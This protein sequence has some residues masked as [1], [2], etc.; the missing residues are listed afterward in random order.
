VIVR[1]LEEI[2]SILFRFFVFPFVRIYYELTTKSVMKQGT[3]TNKGTRL[4]GKNYIG[5]G[6]VLSNVEFGFGSYVSRDS[7]LSNAKVGKYC[8]IGPNMSCL[9]GSHPTKGFVSTHPAF[10]AATSPCGFS[11]S[12]EDIFDENKFTD[13]SKGYFYEIGNDVWIGANVSLGQGVHIG[14]GAIIGANALVLKDVEPYAI[15]AGVPAKKIG[16]RFDEHTV[17]KLESIRW[18]DKGE[19]FIKS[20]IN[21]FSDIN[22][23]LEENK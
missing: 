21:S 16:S 6:T 14:D 23:F 9:G 5:E 20:N 13:K 3:Y 7:I 17:E 19:E 1:K 15:Y 11:Y 22:T 2:L 4:L 18:W 8:S 12:N 10:Y